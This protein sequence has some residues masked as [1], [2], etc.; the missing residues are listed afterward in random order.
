MATTTPDS[1]YFPLAT[2][3][4]APLHTVFAN[5]ASSTQ[6][7]LNK[8]QRFTFVWANSAARTAQT[9]MVAGS[10]GYQ[11]DTKD[12][13]TYTGS[14]WNLNQRIVAFPIS[15]NVGDGSGLHTHTHNLGRTP[16]VAVPT[17]RSNSNDLVSRITEMMF[18][19]NPTV[20][21]TRF[22]A[23]RRDNSTWFSGQ[24][25]NFD[26]VYYLA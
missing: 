3:A 22:R 20:N 1:V 12:E 16:T 23:V 5:L 14:A 18:W 11:V 19:D 25:L 21:T 4:I 17:P 8:R 15:N 26:A 6:T 9:G 2:D 10:T 7:A 24:T 13:Y